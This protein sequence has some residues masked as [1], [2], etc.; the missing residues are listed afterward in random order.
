MDDE[1]G[2]DSTEQRRWPG[3]PLG[4]PESGTGSVAGG[5]RRLLGFVVDIVLAAL[6]AGLFTVPEPPGNW[7]LLT[8]FVITALPVAVF[9]FTPG[10]LLAGIWVARLGGAN[11][12]G[13]WRAIVRCALTAFL[14]PA[15]IRNR[16]GRTWLDRLTGTVVVRR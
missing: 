14:V 12:V 9:G 13:L 5:G 3:E 1:R 6:V 2:P 4:L 16:D 7:S 15:V 11:S 8:W 10:M